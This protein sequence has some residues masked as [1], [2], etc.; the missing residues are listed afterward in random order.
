MVLMRSAKNRVTGGEQKAEA[1]K[2]L[3]IQPPTLI[4]LFHSSYLNFQ[5]IFAVWATVLFDSN[6]SLVFP[7]R[8][9]IQQQHS[10]T[11]CLPCATPSSGATTVSVVSSKDVRNGVFL[12]S[13]RSVTYSISVEF[14]CKQRRIRK[15][16]VAKGLFASRKRLQCQEGKAEAPR[17]EGPQPQPR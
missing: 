3:P 2:K 4:P 7:P 12:K 8:L 17:R 16:T 1:E 5:R 14:H 6:N 9:Q 15:L 13:T 11:A 10:R